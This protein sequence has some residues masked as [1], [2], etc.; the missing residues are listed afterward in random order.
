MTRVVQAWTDLSDI[1]REIE[2]SMDESWLLSL[3]RGLS[4]DES[5]DSHDSENGLTVNANGRNGDSEPD[6]TFMSR[7]IKEAEGR[8]TTGERKQMGEDVVFWLKPE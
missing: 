8:E 7:W 4:S 1:A 6:E 5:K 3:D 2:G